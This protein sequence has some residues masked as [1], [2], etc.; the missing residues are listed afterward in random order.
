M[1]QMGFFDIAN[2]YAGLDAKNDPLVKIDAVV[3][4]EDL[5][6]DLLR[7]EPEAA[8]HGAIQFAPDD[9]VTHIVYENI[10]DIAPALLALL[11]PRRFHGEVVYVDDRS[12]PTAAAP[13]ALG[14]GGVQDAAVARSLYLARLLQPAGHAFDV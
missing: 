5:P 2:R 8:L 14:L 13:H 11:N 9:A 10:E 6:P 12:A 3:P 1:S 4:W 7:V